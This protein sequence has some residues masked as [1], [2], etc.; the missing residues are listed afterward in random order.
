MHLFKNEKI[1]NI[2]MVTLFGL[3]VYSTK[4]TIK[5][6]TQR[7]LGGLI[8]TIKLNCKT[9]ERK[10]VKILN[11]T[12]SERVLENDTMRYYLFGRLIKT[13]H[14]M[15][16]IYDKY[17]K[18]LNIQYD[19]VY[20][21]SSNSGEI[22]LFLAYLAKA[23]FKK[24]NSKA[25]L[26]VATK[27]YHIDILKMYLPTV[28]H[29]FIEGMQLKIQGDA[30]EF[31]GHKFFMIF[32]GSHFERVELAVKNQE[33]GTTHY[34]KSIIDT[35]CV[36][37]DDCYRPNPVISLDVNKSLSNKISEIDLRLNNFVIVAPEALSCSELPM[38]FWEQI[39]SELKKQGYDVFLNITEQ[40]NYINGCKTTLLT[41]SELYSLS[42][43]SRGVISLR[44]GLSEFILPA[45]IPNVSIYTR[46]RNKTSDRAFLVDKGIAGFS[47]FKIPFVNHSMI[48]ELNADGYVSLDELK[49]ITMKSFEKLQSLRESLV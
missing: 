48:V 25:P 10:M 15:Q 16:K 1:D 17:F 49:E 44:S 12:V 8:Y 29:I 3:P 45:N 31:R 37:E 39:V 27:K 5:S 11:K 21:L 28:P 24:N 4:V 41:F 30:F 33:I 13:F 22:F 42:Q 36:S 26:F 7:V 19:D 2:R 9:K 43:K 18:N 46:F 38:G 34:L 32:S 40:K 35:L 47:M 20:I 23:V 6:R 14:L